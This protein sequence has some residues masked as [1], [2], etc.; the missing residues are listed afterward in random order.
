MRIPTTIAAAAVPLALL[1]AAC[2]DDSD[3]AASSGDGRAEQS[4]TAGPEASAD[5][6]EADVEFAQM[7]IPHH[8]GAVDMGALA[9]DRAEAPEILDLAARIQAAQDPEIEQM[10]AWLEEWGEDVPAEDDSGHD[11]GSDTTAAGDMGGGSGGP[12]TGHGMMSADDM[13][14]L[15]AARGAEF[16]R[17]FAEMMIVHHQGAIDMADDEIADGR[18]TDAIDLAHT[19]VA[20]QEAEIAEMQDFLDQSR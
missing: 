4:T 2:G 6:N 10:T 3:D 13:A 16:D 11:M 15:E 19:I 14:A 12:E 5:H 1:A 7:M 9:P 17:V 8:R 20:A 18:F